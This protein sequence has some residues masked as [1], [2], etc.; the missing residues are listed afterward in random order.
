[1]TLF[2]KYGSVFFSVIFADYVHLFFVRIGKNGYKIFV[3][4]K[5]E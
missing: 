5:F 4:V 2:D 3:V 1:M